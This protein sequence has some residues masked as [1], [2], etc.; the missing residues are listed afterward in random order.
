[1]HFYYFYVFGQLMILYHINLC[2][3]IHTSIY[4]SII[5]LTGDAF[6]W[7]QCEVFYYSCS[8]YEDSWSCGGQ[9]LMTLLAQNQLLFLFEA[10][11][12]S[13]LP[14][15]CSGAPSSSS[16]LG[17]NH[18]CW[19]SLGRGNPASNQTMKRVTSQLPQ[20]IILSGSF[21]FYFPKDKSTACLQFSC[22]T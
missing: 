22:H 20:K 19:L 18:T 14:Q 6:T 2:K 4:N 7:S 11:S 13:S 17:H 16:A 3:I 12:M 10:W 15:L 9:F 5:S 8:W 21:T 1:M